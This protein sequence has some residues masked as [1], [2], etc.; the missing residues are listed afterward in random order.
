VNGLADPGLEARLLDACP[1]VLFAHSYYGTCATGTK[2]YAF[3]GVHFCTRTL[4][5][6]CLALHYPRR[7]GGLDPRTMLADYRRQQARRALL[8][9]YRTVL[10][11]SDHMRREYAAHGIAATV[12][13]PP[14]WDALPAADPPPPPAV[15]GGLLFLGRPTPLKGPDRLIRA[16]ALAST[17]LARPLPVTI[18]GG[19]EPHRAL[20]TLARRHGVPLTLS[21]WL[22]PAQRNAVLRK[23][24]LC[25]MPSAWPEPWGM[26]GLEA[27]AAGVPSVA[28]AA[29]GIPEWLSPGVNGELAPV[30]PTDDGLASAIV[31]ALADRARYETLS[32]GA[33]AVARRYD[34]E[35]HVRALGLVLHRAVQG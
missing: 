3:P 18:V 34:P 25:V 19:A 1:A 14:P 13:S 15:G 12:L 11:A 29:G 20:V 28:Y 23:H 27:G 6:G 7:C 24:E 22:P 33:H 9:R 8:G 30:P 31:R 21:G 16:A 5:A 2:R 4:G 17:R 35:A 32:G 26:A 10:V